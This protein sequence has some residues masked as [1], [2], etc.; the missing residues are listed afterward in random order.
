MEKNKNRALNIGNKPTLNNKLFFGDFDQYMVENEFQIFDSLE[1]IKDMA[2]SFMWF[3]KEI[4]VS[5]DVIGWNKLP[6]KVKTIFKKTIAFQNLADSGVA[7]SFEMNIVSIVSTPAAYHL[8]KNISY[9]ESIHTSSYTTGLK[10]A[11]GDKYK[12]VV[13]LVYEDEVIKDRMTKE[14][15]CGEALHIAVIESYNNAIQGFSRMNKLIARDEM[16]VHTATGTAVINILKKYEDQGFKH[17]F[18][19]GWFDEKAREIFAEVQEDEYK[20]IDYLLIDGE[21]PGLTKE[22]CKSFID[23]WVNKRL[24]DIKVEPLQKVKIND[25]IKWYNKT[26]DLGMINQSVQESDTL[27]YQKGELTDD[28]DSYF[29]E[30]YEN[31]VRVKFVKCN[32]KVT[33]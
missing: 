18:D 20:W 17:L 26:R 11:F 24:R 27:V 32:T 30:N 12:D 16:D 28:I 29:G 7:E 25:T 31:N 15:D 8:Y 2:E 21:I 10:K 5:G 23:Y 22:I 13:N 3:T 9:M 1:K 4:D 6:D 33:S 14:L 19:N